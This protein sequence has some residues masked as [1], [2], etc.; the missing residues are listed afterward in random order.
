MSGNA[1]NVLSCT[2]G[3][4]CPLLP[5]KTVAINK[6][7]SWMDVNVVVPLSP[8]KTAVLFDWYHVDAVSRRD[9]LNAELDAS[10]QIQNEDVYISELVQ[11]GL[12]RAR[13]CAV[14]AVSCTRPYPPPLLTTCFLASL[15]ASVPRSTV[16]G[17]EGGR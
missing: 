15:G 11:V 4:S 13:V 10:L 7:G 3:F 9:A 5:R 14:G 16:P 6:F 17:R 2:H 12:R 1:P 8:T